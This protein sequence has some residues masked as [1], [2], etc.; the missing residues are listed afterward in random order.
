MGEAS[1][2]NFKLL[3]PAAEVG[4]NQTKRVHKKN[5]IGLENIML[6][7]LFAINNT[8]ILA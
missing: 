2:D 5:C 3:P 4:F 1:K 8:P 7:R 6:A